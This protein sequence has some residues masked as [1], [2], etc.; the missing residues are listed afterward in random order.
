[1][2]LDRETGEILDP[3]NIS[4]LQMI[5]EIIDIRSR[6]SEDKKELDILNQTVAHRLRDDDAKKFMHPTHQVTLKVT[7]TK[8]VAVLKKL[9]DHELISKQQLIE[10]G[11]YQE[12]K[13]VMK[14][15]EQ[16]EDFNLTHLTPY[17]DYGGEIKAI[18]QEG[19]KSR[20]YRIELKENKNA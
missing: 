14:E 10:D 12:A 2:L 17:E 19:T 1:M 4:T 9:F 11:A 6:M 15:V 5:D 13:I 18:I 7:K 16:K 20:V 3:K 8:D